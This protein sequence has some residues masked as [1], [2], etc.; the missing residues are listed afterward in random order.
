M[1]ALI[2]FAVLMILLGIRGWQNGK[3]EAAQM[4]RRLREEFGKAP[5]PGI[6]RLKFRG[7][8]EKSSSYCVDEITWNDLD[9]DEVY[10]RIN[11][12]HTS[13]GA[14]LLFERL[15]RPA[16]EAKEIEPLDALADQLHEDAALREQLILSLHEI[17]FMGK[18]VL[19]DYMKQIADVPRESGLKL[20]L[21]DALYIVAAAAFVIGPIWGVIALFA[22]I[23]L[24]IT[25]YFNRRAKLS[26]YLSSFAY[27]L[28]MV[29]AG[30][31]LL[32]QTEAMPRIRKDLSDALSSLHAFSR[33][34][35]IA[36][37]MRGEASSNPIDLI[38]DYLKMLFH[39]DLMKFYQMLQ[40]CDR[41]QDEICLLSDTIA[42]LDV[43]QS[44][45]CY[46]ASCVVACKPAWN[47]G[48]LTV[49]DIVHPLLINAVSNS[50]S[51]KD[52]QILVTGSNASGKSTFLKTIAVNAI[53]A[54]AIGVVTASFWS[55]R[56][57]R[58]YSSMALR[59]SLQGGDSF[60]MAEIKSLRRVLD[61]AECSDEPPVL[62]F[63]D[64][65]LKGTNTVERI[66]ASTEILRYLGLKNAVVFAATHDIE[67]TSLLSDLYDNYHFTEEVSDHIMFS[68][69]LKEGRS[70]TRNA[71]R[72]LE[73]IGFPSEVTAHAEQEA[74]RFLREGRWESSQEG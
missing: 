2:I 8:F 70:T 13:S 43:A 37:S 9:L 17:G 48:Q 19:E 72:L 44:I 59:D 7:S 56:F 38:L 15:Y 63:I 4:R 1:T 28:R 65:V 16:M 68:Y 52:R 21:M 10:R 57:Y 45:A 11:Y 29:R 27:V 62:A 54:Q 73:M 66:A 26:P 12:T 69:L 33:F 35:Q 34:S 40:E 6:H 71:I 39:F 22:A 58:I 5:D 49:K 30:K 36:M 46:R 31:L 60:Y 50:I 14:Q 23:A 53:L 3:K 41:R 67:L 42:T 55:G 64:E 25:Y 24:N 51:L 20:W 61:A 47:D 18:Y 74:S 32:P